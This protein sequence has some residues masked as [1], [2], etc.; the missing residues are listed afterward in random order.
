LSQLGLPG[1]FPNP[2]VSSNCYPEF[3]VFNNRQPSAPGPKSGAFVLVR[4]GGFP[5]DCYDRHRPANNDGR[6]RPSI[7]AGQSALTLARR[8]QK[9]QLSGQR[10]SLPRGL[11]RSDVEHLVDAVD[12]GPLRRSA[13]LRRPTAAGARAGTPPAAGPR[14]SGAPQSVEPRPR[15]TLA[16]NVA[17]SPTVEHR[18]STHTCSYPTLS[19]RTTQGQARPDR[20]PAIKSGV[21]PYGV[22]ALCMLVD[23]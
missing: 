3:V 7:N 9:P 8:R 11:E 5:L 22:R 17:S 16:H 23:K 15:G 13:G 6:Q 21:S 4:R 12:R 1:V 18:S 2:F 10:L 20:L 19:Y 14:H